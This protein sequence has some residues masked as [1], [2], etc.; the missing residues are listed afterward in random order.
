MTDDELLVQIRDAA[1]DEDRAYEAWV[2]TEEGGEA[3]TPSPAM[4]E[5]ILARTPRVPPTSEP[6]PAAR[7]AR[8]ISLLAAAAVFL[9]AVALFRP[10]PVLPTYEAEI[11]EGLE[12]KTRGSPL[13]APPHLTFRPGQRFAVMLRPSTRASRDVEATAALVTEGGE[14]PLDV[15]VRIGD[16]GVVHVRGVWPSVAAPRELVLIVVPRDW[17][18]SSDRSGTAPRRVVHVAIDLASW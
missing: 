1:R 13:P 16:A 8:W 15:E 12:Q 4:L 6:V 11:V 5:R 9:A 17:F 18:G 7:R 10:R 14:H 2:A 3:L